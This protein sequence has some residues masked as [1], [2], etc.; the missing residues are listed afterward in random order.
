MKRESSLVATEAAKEQV[1]GRRTVTGKGNRRPKGRKP[2][3]TF[4][5]VCFSLFVNALTS[6]VVTEQVPINT[7]FFFAECE[8]DSDYFVVPFTRNIVP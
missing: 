8:F 2:K 5:F 6:A 1:K 4:T 3:E 7:T